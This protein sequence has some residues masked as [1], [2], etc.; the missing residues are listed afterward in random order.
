M[1][2][3]KPQST[4]FTHSH[5][6]QNEFV[7]SQTVPWQINMATSFSML[8]MW[9]V[10]WSFGKALRPPRIHSESLMLVTV[11]CAGAPP[12]GMPIAICS[13]SVEVKLI[14]VGQPAITPSK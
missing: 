8:D 14:D 6:R 5:T 9:G 1:R 7:L 13:L 12:A 10:E 3:C 11:Q 4:T 2:Y